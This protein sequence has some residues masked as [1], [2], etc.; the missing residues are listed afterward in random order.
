MIKHKIK[1]GDE[2]MV[3]VGRERGKTGKVSRVIPGKSQILVEKLN[4]VKRHTKPSPKHRHGGIIE[5]EAPIHISNVRLICP[6]C[7][8]PVRVGRKDGEGT[9]VCK[10]CGEVVDK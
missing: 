6:K 7:K 5:K 1:K 8:D 9:R 2:V 3:S 10:K 4:I